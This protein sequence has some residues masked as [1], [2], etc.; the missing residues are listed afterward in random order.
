MGSWGFA[1][2]P[3]IWREFQDWF[4]LKVNDKSFHPYVDGIVMTGW[5]KSF[6]KKGTADG[7][8]TMWFIYFCEENRL[9]TLYNNLNRVLGASTHG[10]SVHRQEPGLHFHGKPRADAEKHLL[11]E[12]SPDYI[13]FP[14]NTKKLNY[15]GKE[16]SAG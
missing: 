1:P 8:W 12:W 2:H 10:L 6:E 4:H 15:N 3:K 11:T 7:M 14:E 16:A 5:Y 9:Y 13:A